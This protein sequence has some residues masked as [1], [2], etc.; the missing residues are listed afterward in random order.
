MHLKLGILKHYQMYSNDDFRLTLTILCHGQISFVMLLHEWKLI[1][2][3]VMYAQGF[4]NSAY[5]WA[6]Q[7]HIVFWFQFILS[8]DHY[9]YWQF[10]G[11]ASV[12]ICCYCKCLSDLCIIKEFMPLCFVRGGGGG[13]GGGLGCPLLGKCYPLGFQFLPIRETSPC[14]VT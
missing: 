14:R 1:Q 11:G 13:G 8:I 9:I 5:P 10:L 2:H 12:V 6:T 3:I 4:S 7:D